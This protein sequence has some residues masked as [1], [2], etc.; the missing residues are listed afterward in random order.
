MVTNVVEQFAGVLGRNWWLLLLRGV[1]AIVFGVLV[2]AQPKLS[3]ASLVLVFGAFSL[4]DGLV[5]AWHGLTGQDREHRWLLLLGGL[6]G[7]GIG[8][9]TLMAPGITALALLFYIAI[10]A[11]VQGVL[12]IVAAVRLRKEIEGEWL[13]GAG[14]V[15]SIVFGVLLVAQPGAGALAVLWLIGSFAIGIGIME[16]ALA[17]RVRGFAGGPKASPA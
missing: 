17:F 4:A 10:W 13:L 12:A 16:V 14:G 11:V 3:L 9:L 6:A 7:I 15:A 1:L 5:S 2:F 8:V